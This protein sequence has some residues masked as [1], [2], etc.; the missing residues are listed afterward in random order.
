MN[1]GSNRF[2]DHPNHEPDV[3]VPG[4]KRSVPEPETARRSPSVVQHADAAVAGRQVT[5]FD[6]LGSDTPECNRIIR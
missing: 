3:R 1:P 2:E 6:Q 5:A 4:G